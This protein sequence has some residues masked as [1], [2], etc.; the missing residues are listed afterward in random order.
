M[1][2]NFISSKDD[3]DEEP[4]THFKINVVEIMINDIAGEVI[5]KIFEL[6]KKIY[7]NNLEE[8]IKD[9]EFVFDYVY[10][11]NYKC[12]KTNPNRGRSYAD[13]PNWIK[14]KKSSKRSYQ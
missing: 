6:L 8:S 10:L 9:S 5:K 12:H 14:N 3:N 4:K 2:I 13:S 7:Q 11:L 1:K